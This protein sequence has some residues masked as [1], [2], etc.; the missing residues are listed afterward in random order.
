MLML[1]SYWMT[2]AIN[3]DKVSDVWEVSG[4]EGM[5][6]IPV[7]GS[8]LAPMDWRSS[9]RLRMRGS[10][11]APGGGCGAEGWAGWLVE[12]GGLKEWTR[13]VNNVAVVKKSRAGRTHGAAEDVLGAV[14]SGV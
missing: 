9:R 12:D 6:G 8:V 1:F 2:E 7:R 14:Q 4:T 11:I 3:I 5:S 13:L 10:G